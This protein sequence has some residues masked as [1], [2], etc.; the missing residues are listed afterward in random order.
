MTSGACIWEHSLDWSEVAPDV[1]GESDGPAR[2]RP[3]VP[4][5]ATDVG[6]VRSD[7]A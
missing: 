6:G 1:A 2:S 5:V 7:C 4:V 3:W